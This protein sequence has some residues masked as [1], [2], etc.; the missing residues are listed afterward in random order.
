[1]S[2]PVVMTPEG[3]AP[4]SLPDIKAKIIADATAMSP[5]LT[6]NLP[7]SLIDD[8][9]STD[10]AAIA[11]CDS[12][13]VDL[14]NSLTPYGANE[15]L[16]LQLGNMYGISKDGPSNTSVSIVA[17]GSTPGFVIAQGFIVSDGTNQF[18]TQESTLVSADGSSP[19]IFCIATNA[20]SFAVPE[21]TVS[22]LVTSVPKGVVLTVTNPQTGVPGV[23]AQSWEAYRAAVL[24]AGLAASSGMASTLRKALANVPGVQARLVSVRIATGSNWEVIVGGGDPYQVA[25]AIFLSLF[26]LPNLVG[27]QIDPT[28]DVVVTIL[29]FPDMYDIT[30]VNPPQQTVG[31]AL[32][33]NTTLTNFTSDAAF[34][35]AA[36]PAIINY[37]NGIYAGQPMNLFALD[38]AVQ[39]AVAAVIPTDNLTRLVFNVTIN[40]SSAPPVSGTGI[41]N[42]DPEGFFFTDTTHVTVDRG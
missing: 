34:A 14:I 8:I 5:G 3:A 32:T 17:T 26:N 2:L 11:Q 1:M 7:P 10:T 18:A 19:P 24:T 31:V 33:W 36:T 23:D 22:D 41:I 40:G 21:N 38:E 37:V 15:F 29:D 13:Q 27:S 39:E 20:G 12:S 28:R 42:G 25:N 30:F 16:L 9:V 35:Q 6:A 4:Q